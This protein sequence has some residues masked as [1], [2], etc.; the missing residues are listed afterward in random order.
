MITGGTGFTGRSLA[1]R[2]RKDGHEVIALGHEASGASLA[3]E[4]NDI[5]S[6]VRVVSEIRPS[7]VVHLAAIAAPYTATS[8]KSTLSM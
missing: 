1:E 3:I 2:L 5:N 4:L 8:A 7:A 6:L